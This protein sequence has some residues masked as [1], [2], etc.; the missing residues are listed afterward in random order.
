MHRL[1]RQNDVVAQNNF[2]VYLRFYLKYI[3]PVNDKITKGLFEGITLDNLVSWDIIMGF[4]FENLILN[5]VKSVCKYLNINLSTV[6]SAGYYF[7]KMTKRQMA[8]QIDLLIQTKYTLYICEIKF[9]NFISKQVI[10]EVQKKINILKVPKGISIRPILIYSGELEKSILKEDFFD[11]VIC[12]E[13][14]LTGQ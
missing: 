1:S 2:K 11:Q 7:Q 13:D 12:F 9:R 5:N 3:E 8:C 4:Q 6:K 10:I 14:F